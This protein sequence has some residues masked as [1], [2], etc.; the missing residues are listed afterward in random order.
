[1]NR[2]ANLVVWPA[3]A[4][5]SAVAVH[6]CRMA[7]QVPPAT[8][9]DC[10]LP[11]VAL[12]IAIVAWV[13]HATLLA[14]V[15][16]LM[17]LLLAVPDERLRLLGYGVVVSIVFAV[18]VASGKGGVRVALA[19]LLV[20]RWLPLTSVLWIRELLLLAIAAA[21]VFVLRATPL[22]VAIGAAVAFVTPAVP[23]RSLFFPL[24]VLVA[25]VVARFLGFPPIE[26]RVL[27][28][29]VVALPLLF[30]AW[31]GVVARG[32]PLIFAPYAPPLRHEVQWALAP[33]KSM[34]VWLPENAKALIVSGANVP[35]LA[36]GTPL[37]RIEPDGIVVRVGDAADWG[38]MRREH[39]FKAR[40]RL[41][42]DPAG[43]IRDYGYIAWVDGAGRIPLRGG[44]MITITGDANLPA[45]ASLQVEAVEL[46]R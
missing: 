16:L 11:F 34:E 12:V 9:I 14:A 2:L 41:P 3:A 5:L 43:M 13:T 1:M 35:R 37:G 44:R 39:W 33:A 10:D 21:I 20:L 27:P 4:V 28:A 29:A 6:L 18:A 23:L 32:V 25:A 8:P 38:F 36:P 17:A 45:G 24:A 31:S 40:N 42:R 46:Q 30:L 7:V 15:P 26:W 19:A 22:A